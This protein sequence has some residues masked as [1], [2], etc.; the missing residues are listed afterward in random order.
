MEMPAA[1][2][3][4]VELREWA[5]QLREWDRSGSFVHLILYHDFESC[6]NAVTLRGVSSAGYAQRATNAT[7][8][9]GE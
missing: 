6:L 5:R 4:I 3:G 9:R 7:L 8:W 2:I 1:E